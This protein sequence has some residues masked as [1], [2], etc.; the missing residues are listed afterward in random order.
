MST[1]LTNIGLADALE[2][3]KDTR[4]YRA[5]MAFD[6]P[7]DGVEQFT[8]DVIRAAAPIIRRQVAEEIAQAIEAVDPVEWAL[9][10][11][12]AGQ[13]AAA[14]ARRVGDPS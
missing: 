1:D 13:D 9:A 8:A 6:V 2:A 4:A 5:G 7:A 11:Q 10:G 3:A 14:I 12:H